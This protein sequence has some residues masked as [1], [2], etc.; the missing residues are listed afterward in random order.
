MDEL[1][2]GF[3]WVE[4]FD[5]TLSGKGLDAGLSMNFD[6]PRD[7][8]P[9]VAILFDMQ[10]RELLGRD[11]LELGE[12]FSVRLQKIE[13]QGLMSLSAMAFVSGLEIE[14]IRELA[15]GGVQRVPLTEHSICLYVLV[16]KLCPI[17]SERE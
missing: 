16:D 9:L 11:Y 1:F 14:T 10:K 8:L 13:S 7:V 17:A 15:V 5:W 12:G 2:S 4:R 6:C 3:D